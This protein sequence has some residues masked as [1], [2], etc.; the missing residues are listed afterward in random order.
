MI[1][2]LRKWKA[3][4]FLGKKQSSFALLQGMIEVTFEDDKANQFLSN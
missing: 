3:N 2:N 1:R 4:Q